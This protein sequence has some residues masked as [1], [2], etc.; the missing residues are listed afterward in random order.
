[1]TFSSE[2]NV[3]LL[4]CLNLKYHFMIVTFPN[5]TYSNIKKREIK[6]PKIG[7]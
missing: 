4:F 3:K 6:N 1:M 2:A 7:N 5:V